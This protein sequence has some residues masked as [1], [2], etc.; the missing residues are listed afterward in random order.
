[1]ISSKAMGRETS[2]RGTALSFVGPLESLG[3]PHAVIVV[4]ILAQML[5]EILVSN[6]LVSSL[7][8]AIPVGMVVRNHVDRTGAFSHSHVGRISAID[9]FW[10]YVSE[11]GCDAPKRHGRVRKNRND[12]AESIRPRCTDSATSASGA[13]VSASRRLS[14]V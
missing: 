8:R 13:S 9:T 11:L 6:R 7:S 2:D 5:L 14:R 10:K 1:M 12:S 3:G 4:A